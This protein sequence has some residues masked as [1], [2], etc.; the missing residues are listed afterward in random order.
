MPVLKRSIGTMNRLIR[1]QRFRQTLS[2]YDQLTLVR[3][4]AKAEAILENVPDAFLPRCRLL[5]RTGQR[6]R[7]PVCER[8][9]AAMQE[10]LEVLERRHGKPVV[11]E[12]K[13]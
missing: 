7:T 6:N 12:S 2:S 13:P 4:Y 9:Y 11:E 3:A 8:D 5:N 1:K 10:L